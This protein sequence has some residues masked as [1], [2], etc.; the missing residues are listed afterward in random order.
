VGNVLATSRIG[1]ACQGMGEQDRGRAGLF[2]FPIFIKRFLGICV[3][4]IWKL[5]IYTDIRVVHARIR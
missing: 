1:V 2:G 4:I 3:G 5:E